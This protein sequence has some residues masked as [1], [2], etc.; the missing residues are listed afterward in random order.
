ML[1]LIV[2]KKQGPL[3]PVKEC[4]SLKSTFFKRKGS[5]DIEALKK[6]L[7]IVPWFAGREFLVIVFSFSRF[8][9]KNFNF[10]I[11]VLPP[12]NPFLVSPD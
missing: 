1:T 8:H 11:L 2:L 5:R 6:G 4:R 7:S 3:P 12:S 10:V 9:F